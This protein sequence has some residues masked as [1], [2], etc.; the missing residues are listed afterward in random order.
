M[1]KLTLTL[2]LLLSCVS[3]AYGMQQAIE[4][5]NWRQYV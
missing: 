4:Q 1:K 3:M 2:G 5:H